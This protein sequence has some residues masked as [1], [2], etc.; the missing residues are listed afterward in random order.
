[1]IPLVSNRAGMTRTWEEW[2][3]RQW[4]G[5]DD[6]SLITHRLIGCAWMGGKLDPCFRSMV[7]VIQEEARLRFGQHFSRHQL[8]SELID[9][10]AKRPVSSIWSIIKV[11]IYTLVDKKCGSYEESSC[12]PLPRRLSGWRASFSSEEIG[13]VWV[14]FSRNSI[15]RLLVINHLLPLRTPKIEKQLIKIR[16]IQEIVKNLRNLITRVNPEHRCIESLRLLWIW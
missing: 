6:K 4:N 7:A 12:H 5:A 16:L 13:S 11:D 3:D 14:F 10:V 8:N 9:P 2:Q 1:M 15:L